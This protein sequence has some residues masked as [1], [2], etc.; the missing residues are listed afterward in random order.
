VPWHFFHIIFS[1]YF[2]Y[3]NIYLERENKSTLADS[4]QS[5]LRQIFECR[6]LQCELN[7]TNNY[8]TACRLTVVLILTYLHALIIIKPKLKD[9]L[10]LFVCQSPPHPVFCES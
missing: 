4:E 10:I 5:I 8:T 9:V 6:T 3:H 1:T 2:N 7:I